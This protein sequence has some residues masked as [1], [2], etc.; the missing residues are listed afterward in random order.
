ME[1]YWFK[2]RILLQFIFSSYFYILLHIHI[3]KNKNFKSAFP[4]EPGQT[5]GFISRSAEHPMLQLKSAEDVRCFTVL[6][7][8]SFIYWHLKDLR[9]SVNF[10]FF[11]LTLNERAA[12]LFGD[13]S[14]SNFPSSKF[15]TYSVRKE[16]QLNWLLSTINIHLQSLQL[17]PLAE[18]CV[19]LLPASSEQCLLWT[20]GRLP[21]V[22]DSLVPENSRE[23]PWFPETF[24]FPRSLFHHLLFQGRQQKS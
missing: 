14:L 22:V 6:K 17:L 15:P 8:T 10:L 18:D 21:Y 11:F 12:K 2:F 9:D 16:T 19:M 3:C 23:T 7:T 4:S 20:S 1:H 5:N 13:S 24:S